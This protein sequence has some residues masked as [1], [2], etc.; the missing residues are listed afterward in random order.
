MRVQVESK[1]DVAA[2]PDRVWGFLCDA[3]LPLIAPCCFKIGVP[4]PHSCTLVS[5]EG[6]VG[7][8]RQCRTGDGGGWRGSRRYQ[9]PAF[10][11]S[12]RAQEVHQQ[13]REAQRAL[14]SKSRSDS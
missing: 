7:A 8:Q 11:L 14:D 2:A 4:T 1:V 5:E 6:R 12:E 9:P 13:I 10:E 3:K